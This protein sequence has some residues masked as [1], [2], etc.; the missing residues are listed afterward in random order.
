[1]N[2]VRNSVL[3]SNTPTV[4]ECD[5]QAT[6]VGLVLTT[7]GDGGHGQMPSSTVDRRPSPV[8]HTQ[9]LAVCTAVSYTHLTL[10]TIL[11]V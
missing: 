3:R 6:V 11:R 8:D 2:F 10:P 5:K 7:L 9:H 1:M 4:A